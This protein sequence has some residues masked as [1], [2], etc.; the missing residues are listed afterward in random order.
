MKWVLKPNGLS[1]LLPLP[2]ALILVLN[3]Q[4]YL[5]NDLTRNAPMPYGAQILLIYGLKMALYTLIVSWT[6][7]PEKS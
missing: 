4:T 3:L 5:M 1:L 6:C 2:E 7:L